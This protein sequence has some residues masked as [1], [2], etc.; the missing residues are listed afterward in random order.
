MK[1]FVHA[2]SQRYSYMKRG[3]GKPWFKWLYL[4]AF[5]FA[6]AT[7]ATIWSPWFFCWRRSVDTHFR[8]RTDY[9]GRYTEDTGVECWIDQY[10]NGA[11][12]EDAFLEEV[13][14]WEGD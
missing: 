14:H 4:D 1:T 5:M 10:W 13:S 8:N 12:P 2:F 6:I 11:N 7:T 9:E 3:W